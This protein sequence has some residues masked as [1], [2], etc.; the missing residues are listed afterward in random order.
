[1][2][3][4]GRDGIKKALKRVKARSLFLGIDNDI[5]FPVVEQKMLTDTVENSWYDE[6]DSIYG[7]DGFLLEFEKLTIAIN[8]FYKKVA[9]R[10]KTA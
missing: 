4:G 1:M 9:A 2:W 7:H 8:N 5:L 10:K 3:E 6:I